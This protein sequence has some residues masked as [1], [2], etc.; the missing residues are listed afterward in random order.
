MSD[1]GL[2]LQQALEK[3]SIKELKEASSVCTTPVNPNRSYSSKHPA[4]PA[5]GTWTLLIVIVFIAFNAWLFQ[6]EFSDKQESEERE[7]AGLTQPLLGDSQDEGIDSNQDEINEVMEVESPLR[8]KVLVSN[9]SSL[10][11]HPSIHNT[12]RYCFPIVLSLTIILLLTSNLSTGASVDLQVIKDNGQSLIPSINIYEFSLSSTLGEMWRAGVYMLMLLIWFCSGVWPYVKLIL[13]II[14][15]VTSTKTL[16]PIKREKILYL[17]DCLG[18]FSL[19]DAYV[20]VL[21]MVA[22]RYNL[23]VAGVGA[24]DVYV[25]PKYVSRS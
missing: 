9:S 15:W 16:P 22:F 19:I 4:G 12:L 10:M 18:K 6:R 21:M 25:T 1:G 20:L 2:Q 7:S 8:Q 24:V 11:Y 17:L 13:M 3:L 23:D 14:C 5:A